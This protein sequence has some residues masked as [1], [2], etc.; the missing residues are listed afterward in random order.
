MAGD[1]YFNGSALTGQHDVKL[2]GTDMDNVYLNGTKIWTRHPYAIGTEIFNVSFSAGGN[3]DSFINSTYDSYPLAFTARPSYTT[4][5]SGSLD[6]VCTFILAAGFYVSYYNQN[7]HG[8][9]SDGVGAANTG[10]NYSVYIGGTVSGL[11]RVSGGGS[12]SIAGS[13]NNGHS[14]KVTYSGQ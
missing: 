11:S 9:D 1:I 4:G 14:F 12:L 5:S 8:T 7:E 6:K 3:C 13:G 10:G 2:N